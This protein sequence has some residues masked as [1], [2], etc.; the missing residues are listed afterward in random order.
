MADVLLD[1]DLRQRLERLGTNRAALFSWE[2]AA[3][4]TLDVYFSVAGAKMNMRSAV[5]AGV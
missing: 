4:K 3:L 2:K 5:R 1:Q